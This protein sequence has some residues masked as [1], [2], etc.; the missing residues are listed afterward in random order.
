M[1][2]KHTH[3]GGCACGNVRYR[4]ESGPLVVHC[5]HCT[6]CQRESGSAFA[7]NA[8]IEATR[9]SLLAGEPEPVAVPSASGSGQVFWRCPDCRVAVWSHYAGAG[10][11]VNF[12]R[13][14]TLDRAADV[15][16]D[17]HIY[18]TTRHPWVEIPPGVPSFAEYYRRD[19][20]WSAE[21]LERRASLLAAG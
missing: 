16:P 15:S 9:V 20:V 19:E 13:V 5:C 21:S 11:K 4:M 10:E 6:W 12:I 18:T 14:G 8:L 1:T 2:E 3:E 17:V 7:L